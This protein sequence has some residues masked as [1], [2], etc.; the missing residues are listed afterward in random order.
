MRFHPTTWL[1]ASG[2]SRPKTGGG[3]Q[4]V[5]VTQYSSLCWILLV[6]VRD[7]TIPQ[8]ML[9]PSRWICDSYSC[10]YGEG[11]QTVVVWVIQ[12]YMPVSCSTS[13]GSSVRSYSSL[14]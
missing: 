2:L 8:S 10:V 5:F 7:N 4:C 1:L 12:Q 9:E 13:S 3:G 6:W 11:V 14:T